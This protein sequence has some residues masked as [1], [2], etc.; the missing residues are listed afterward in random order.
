MNLNTTGAA[1]N[2]ALLSEVDINDR[3]TITIGSPGGGGF[4]ERAILRGGD[5]RDRTAPPA[6]TWTT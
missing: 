2:W 3:V 5:P 4:E 6:R 1:A